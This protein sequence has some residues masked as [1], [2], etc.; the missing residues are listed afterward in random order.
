[1]CAQIATALNAPRG[2][3]CFERHSD[4]FVCVFC[5]RR[6]QSEI[7]FKNPLKPL[8]RF[9]QPVWHIMSVRLWG[10]KQYGAA[11]VWFVKQGAAR[12]AAPPLP[13]L[14]AGNGDAAPNPT[15]KRKRRPK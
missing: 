11:G 12:A 1:M 15:A 9:H 5:T 14:V 6:A 3:L 7:L 2:L 13:E 4:L 8:P 10:K